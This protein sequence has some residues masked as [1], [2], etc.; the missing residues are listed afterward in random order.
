MEK[1]EH[2]RADK[3]RKK[4]YFTSL[5]PCNR[6]PEQNDMD[7]PPSLFMLLNAGTELNRLLDT[8]FYPA[9]IA[10]DLPVFFLSKKHFFPKTKSLLFPVNKLVRE[11]SA[12]ADDC[13]EPKGFIIS[14]WNKITVSLKC[15]DRHKEP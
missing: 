13:F 11:L 4:V 6:Q 14:R 5:Y 10:Q 9:L 15:R 8:P 12:S 7:E 1:V 2:P 3:M